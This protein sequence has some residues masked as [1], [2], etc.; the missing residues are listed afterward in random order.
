MENEKFGNEFFTGVFYFTNATEEDFAHLWNSKEY[1]FPAGTSCPLI[2][3]NETL[4]NIQEIRK[5]FAYDLAVREFYKGKEYIRMSK[6]GNGLPPTFDEKLLQP[7]IDQC[8]SP[9]PKAI[10]KVK[11]GKKSP[12]DDEQNYTSKALKTGEDPNYLFK[13]AVVEEKGEMSI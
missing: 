5:R 3:P 11:Q 13:D 10:A 8:L 9:L 6:M 7:W 12:K 4:E 2:I 1:T